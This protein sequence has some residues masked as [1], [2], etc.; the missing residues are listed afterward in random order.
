MTSKQSSNFIFEYNL[1]IFEFQFAWNF[2]YSAK[3]KSVQL[4]KRG[5]SESL[6]RSGFAQI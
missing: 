1:T 4:F 6:A 5:I 3:K 2:H